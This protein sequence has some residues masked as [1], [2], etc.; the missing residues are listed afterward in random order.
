MTLKNAWRSQLKF[1]LYLSG[2][3]AFK[4]S[5]EKETQV[6]EETGEEQV[7]VRNNFMSPDDAEIL[8]R[9]I[10]MYRDGFVTANQLQR[11]F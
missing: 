1:V 7:V 6:N 8:W 2:Q 9:D 3:A 5:G 10:D 11:F 4:A